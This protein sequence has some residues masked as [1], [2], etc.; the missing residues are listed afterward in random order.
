[1]ADSRK[2]GA[3]DSDGEKVVRETFEVRT[4]DGIR[5]FGSEKYLADSEI[6][7]T[8]LLLHPMTALGHLYLDIPFKD[9]HGVKSP[10]DLPLEDFMFLHTSVPSGPPADFD[11][12]H[13]TS[14]RHATSLMASSCIRSL[15]PFN[16]SQTKT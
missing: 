14:H 8:V 12:Q 1:M 4:D 16:I 10:L 3:V 6:R 15:K 9:Y 5:I 11:L 13:G 7:G 2:S